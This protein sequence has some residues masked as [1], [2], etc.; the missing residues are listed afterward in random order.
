MRCGRATSGNHPADRNRSGLRD[1]RPLLRV[2]AGVGEPWTRMPWVTRP[3][4]SCTAARPGPQT[5][6]PEEGFQNPPG[7]W[8]PISAPSAGHGAAEAHLLVIT[9]LA[10][11]HC[12][13]TLKHCLSALKTLTL[14]SS[15]A[16]FEPAHGACPA[17]SHPALVP[18][19]TC[20][21]PC[22]HQRN[23]E[24]GRKNKSHTGL[25]KKLS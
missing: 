15:A 25:E 3:H 14:P 12:F 22:L 13:W 11:M 7:H 9:L 23:D 1:H 10:R 16:H 6:A 4:F 20:R 5:A 17:V 21:T 2:G 24:F 8:S 18:V 19:A